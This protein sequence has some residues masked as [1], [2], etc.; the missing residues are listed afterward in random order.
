[1]AAVKKE[2]C[3]HV[4]IVVGNIV[5]QQKVDILVNS[6]SMNLRFGSVVVV[7]AIHSVAGPDLLQFVANFPHRNGRI[8]SNPRI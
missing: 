5:H 4:K 2:V 8:G 1:M 7:G 3:L 6:A